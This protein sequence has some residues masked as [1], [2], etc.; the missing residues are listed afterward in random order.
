[1]ILNIPLPEETKVS[2]IAGLRALARSNVEQPLAYTT[3]LLKGTPLASLESRKRHKMKTKYRLLPRQ[4]GEYLGKRVVEYDEVC[5]AT[6]TLSYKDY[7]ECRGLSLVFLSLSSQQYNFL[8]L[9]CGELAVDWFDLLLEIWETMRERKGGLGNLYKEF[10]DASESE[11]F[12]SPEEIFEF[13]QNNESYKQLLNG[14]VGETIMRNF[15]PRMIIDYFNETTDL[16]IS[17]L[18]K[19]KNNV[20]WLPDL[21]MWAKATRNVLPILEERKCNTSEDIIRL[22]VDVERW[23]SRDGEEPIENFTSKTGYKLVADHEAIDRAVDSM[24]RLYGPDRL[25]WA[26]RLLETKPLEEMWKKCVVLN[27]VT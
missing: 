11:L 24:I 22:N 12:D 20:H 26:S 6:K 4:F 13:V 25:R 1:M 23:I 9:T 27:Q 3:M 10:I 16:A 14:E 5:V 8:R 21:R 19:A 18:E 2:F 15:V 17:L 7:L